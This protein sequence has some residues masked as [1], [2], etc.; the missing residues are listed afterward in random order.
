MEMVWLGVGFLIGMSL[1]LP[2]IIDAR[3]DARLAQ[4]AVSSTYSGTCRPQSRIDSS[5]IRT[6]V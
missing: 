2:F 1:W 3:L 4:L 6:R 5:E